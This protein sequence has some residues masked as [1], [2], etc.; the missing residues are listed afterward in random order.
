MKKLRVLFTGGGTGGHIFPLIS[1]AEELEKQAGNY[2]V[3]VDF[4][5][6]GADYQYAEAIVGSGMDFVPIITSKWRRYWS[7]MN[8]IDI[9][10]FGLS[11]IQLLWKIFWFMPDAV[12]S[13]GG[14]GSLAVVLVSRF[15]FIPV[16]IHESDSVPGLTNKI[17]GFFY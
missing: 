4:R 10:K 9:F 1:V 5:Y 2:G 16:V 11:I 6:F 3:L 13:K 7:L 8:F 17:S 14:P 12:F 15:Y